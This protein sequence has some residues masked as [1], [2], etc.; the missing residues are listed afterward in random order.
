M[1]PRSLVFVDT[2][3][4]GLSPL[5]DR[6]IEIGMLRVEDGKLVDTF[7]TLINP[8][9]YVSPF[10]E[11][12]TGIKKQELDSAPP[13]EDVHRNIFDFLDDAVFV[14]HNARFDYGFL[15]NEFKRVEQPFSPKH[16]CTAKLSRA[17]YPDLNHHNLDSIIERFGFRV[18][19]RHRAFDDA[20]I[21]WKFYQAIQKTFSQEL[22]ES[23]VNRGMKRPSLPKNLPSNLVENLPHTPG[24][25]IFYGEQG[26]PLYVGK[27]KNLKDRVL[28]HF[29][30]DYTSGKEMHIAQQ[31]THIETI[32]TCGELGALVKEAQL[33]KKLQPIYNRKLRNSRKL[34]KLS[35]KPNKDGFEAV[36]METVQTI[37]PSEISSII[38]IFKSQRQA[39]QFLIDR[40]KEFTLCEKLLGIEK[41]KGACFAYRLGACNGACIAAEKPLIYNFRFISGLSKYKLKAWPFTGPIEIFEKDEQGNTES[42]TIENWCFTGH[43][44]AKEIP[45][46]EVSENPV[47]DLDTYKILISFL[48]HSDSSRFSLR[49][50]PISNQE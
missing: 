14:A 17:L 28:S 22:L 39:K 46:Q 33:V 9:M 43:T 42:F 6:I 7:E 47:F 13:F 50:L 45:M 12:L 27:S 5:R 49:Q 1:L 23:A 11:E 18:E 21:L 25:Y 44:V 35:H 36:S 38:G 34:I 31:I 40:A 4:T 24:V 32:Q 48:K 26:V 41:T 29:T 20:E 8:N 3:T 15:K 19:R 16:F 30:N 10:I 2:E 37:L